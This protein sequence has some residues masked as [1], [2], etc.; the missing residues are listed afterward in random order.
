MNRLRT[1]TLARCIVCLLLFVLWPAGQFA[2][3]ETGSEPT[4]SDCVGKGK[5]CEDSQTSNPSEDEGGRESKEKAEQPKIGPTAWDYV[6]TLVAFIFVIGLLVWLL[7]FLNKRNRSFD[8]TQFMKNLGGVPLGQQKSIQLVKM[9]DHYF[10]V[11]VGETVEL[12]KEITDP[13]EVANLLAYYEADR[14][15]SS[16]NPIVEQ[17]LKRVFNRDAGNQETKETANDFGQVF[18]RKMEEMK[19]DRKRQI[20]R[21]KKKESDRNE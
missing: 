19:A 15:T 14:E 4:V 13:D 3:A 6:K 18:N 2:H 16:D 5:D 7:R 10:V 8:Q 11:G 17:L 12:L 1:Y 9:G 21:L 20:D